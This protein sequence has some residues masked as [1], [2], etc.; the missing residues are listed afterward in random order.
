MLFFLTDIQAGPKQ[1]TK[2]P[3]YQAKAFFLQS[4]N[5]PLIWKIFLSSLSWLSKS[6]NNW[7]TSFRLNNHVTIT[8]ILIHICLLFLFLFV[9]VTYFLLLL[10]FSLLTTGFTHAGAPAW[11][12]SE[13]IIVH[14]FRN[15]QV[16]CLWH[17][18]KSWILIFWTLWY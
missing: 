2:F 5:T 8:Y 4:L 11:S 3:Q 17:K 10:S 9:Q 14:S 15:G 12:P 16:S 18:S 1:N 7:S 6:S 13:W